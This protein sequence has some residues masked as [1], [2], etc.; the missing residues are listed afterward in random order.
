MKVNVVGLTGKK[1]S[2]KDAA[3]SAL[4]AEGWVRLAYGDPLKQEVADAFCVAPEI[5]HD[6]ELKE[7]P[8]ASLALANCKDMGFVSAMGWDKDPHQP[9]SPRWVMQQWGTDYRRKQD[10]N[11]WVARTVQE[12]R[13]LLEYG[14]S[15]VVTDVRFYNEATALLELGGSIVKVV[16][17]NNPYEEGTDGH[18]SETEMDSF[19]AAVELLNNGTQAELGALLC[20]AVK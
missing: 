18:A 13:L 8:L 14:R 16:R 9:R 4:V 5:F 6:R 12:V 17:P 3:A 19:S 15:V 7:T 1:G 10:G 11:Y 2:G 20:A